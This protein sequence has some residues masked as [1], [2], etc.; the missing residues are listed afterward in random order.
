MKSRSIY[1]LRTTDSCVSRRRIFRRRS[2]HRGFELA[3]LFRSQPKTTKSLSTT[4]NSTA[5]AM[6]DFPCSQTSL[7]T[8]C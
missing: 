6:K 2:D 4:T 8:A 3:V 1:E 7:S 5:P